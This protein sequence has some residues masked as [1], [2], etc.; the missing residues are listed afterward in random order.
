MDTLNTYGALYGDKVI[1]IKAKST[2][3]AQQL[4]VI[5]FQKTAGRKKIQ[6]YQVTVMLARLATS[7]SDVIHVADF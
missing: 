1:E 5:E 4:A 2:Y 3:E 7:D 6:G